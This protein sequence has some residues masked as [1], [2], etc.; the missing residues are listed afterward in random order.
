MLGNSLYSLYELEPE[1]LGEFVRRRDIGALNV[2]IPYKIDV[3][4]HLDVISPEAE[5][6]GSVNTV[7]NRGGRL[8]GYNTDLF[9]FDYTLRRSGISLSGKKVLIFGSGGSSQ[10]V[11]ACAKSAGAS[12]IVI[13]SRSGP[14]NYGNLDR[15]KDAQIPPTP[16]P[17]GCI[18]NRTKCLLTPHSSPAAG[19]ADLITIR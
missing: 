13:I 2:T 4:A 10:T 18:P 15:H 19:V 11:R 1:Q 8:Y 6:I 17:S 9:G 12:Q 5:S 3:M 14:D 7:V 16:R